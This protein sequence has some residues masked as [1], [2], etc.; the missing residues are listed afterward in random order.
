MVWCFWVLVWFGLVWSGCWVV[1][2]GDLDDLICVLWRFVG[3][4]VLGDGYG[5]GE[6]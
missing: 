1:V 6:G 5:E 4:S 3:G 2:R